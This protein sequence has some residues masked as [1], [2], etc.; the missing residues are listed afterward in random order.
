GQLGQRTTHAS[1][2][3]SSDVSF[4][5]IRF[6]ASYSSTLS[7]SLAL[8]SVWAKIPAFS[9]SD[10]VILTRLGTWTS[11]SRCHFSAVSNVAG[12][13][14]GLPGW[15]DAF[16]GGLSSYSL[17]WLPIVTPRA[18][19]FWEFDF[20]TSRRRRWACPSGSGA[21]SRIASRTFSSERI[22]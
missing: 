14:H 2:D 19:G 5:H 10:R 4:H 8:Y 13:G 15:L 7:L 20:V 12:T 3:S 1:S 11:H 9:A 18:H 21:S 6:S 22:P 17:L 16:T